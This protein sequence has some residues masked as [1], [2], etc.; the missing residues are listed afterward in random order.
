[1]TTGATDGSR[2]AVT[3]GLEAGERVVTTGGNLVRLAEGG[4][5]SAD[6]HAGHIH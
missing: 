6:P 1:M 3:D 5:A 2:V 4:G